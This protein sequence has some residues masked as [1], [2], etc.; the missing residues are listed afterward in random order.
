VSKETGGSIQKIA[1]LKAPDEIEIEQDKTY[2]IIVEPNPTPTYSSKLNKRWEEFY[3]QQNFKNRVLFLTGSNITLQTVRTLAAQ[4]RAIKAIIAE[5]SLEQ[6]T[7]SDPRKIEAT[8]DREA[9]YA[10]LKMAL[11]EAFHLLLYPAK[12]SLKEAAFTFQ[13]EGNGFYGEREIKNTLENK[14]KFTTEFEGESF[15][16]KCEQRLFGEQKRRSWSEVKKQAAV[17]PHWPFHHP[18]ALEVLKKQA[19]IEARW[20]QEG[21]FINIEPPPPKATVNI[22]QHYRDPET[23]EASLKITPEFGNDVYY[24]EGEGIPNTEVAPFLVEIR[25]A[26]SHHQATFASLS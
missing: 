5:D 6:L 23:G 19:I 25:A 24:E 12:G 16:K 18:Q 8:K 14:A 13:F 17:N 4:Y 15:R 9:I 11:K 20:V 3:E 22:S 26:P 10:R 21:D 2:L 7:D 1:I